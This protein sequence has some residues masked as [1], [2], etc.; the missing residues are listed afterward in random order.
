MRGLLVPLL[1]VSCVNTVRFPPDLWNFGPADTGTTTVPDPAP[2]DS[3]APTGGPV[4]LSRVI[5]D[6]GAELQR[7][8][9]ITTGWASE[10]VLDV[11]HADGRAESHGLEIVEVDP[12]GAWDQWS[13][14]LVR[15]V[16]KGVGVTGFD[17]VDDEPFLT[18]ALRVRTATD[19]LSDC[20]TWGVNPNQMDLWLT[21]NE[22]WFTGTCRPI[23]P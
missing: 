18:Y 9:A 17:C 12:A 14:E 13:V 7:V 10:I 16:A 11:L 2:F 4:M 3:G 20:G 23:D 5:V 6:C 22:P 1:A 19:P 15:G 8:E 21:R